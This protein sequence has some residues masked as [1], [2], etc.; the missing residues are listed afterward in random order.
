VPACTRYKGQYIGGYFTS[1]ED[2]VVFVP[3]D[4]FRARLAP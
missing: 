2:G 1:R 3:Y 4:R